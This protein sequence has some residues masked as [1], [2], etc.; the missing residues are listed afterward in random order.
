MGKKRKY[1]LIYIL[2]I[3][4]LIFFEAKMEGRPTLVFFDLET[5]GLINPAIVQVGAVTFDQNE[6]FD[7]FLTPYKPFETKASEVNNLSINR[8]GELVRFGSIDILSL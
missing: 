2:I 3:I 8:R 5:T 4:G 1:Y 6:T 7:E